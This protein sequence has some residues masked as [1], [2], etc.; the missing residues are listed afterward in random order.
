[1]LAYQ[2]MK[3]PHTFIIVHTYMQNIHYDDNKQCLKLPQVI[4]CLSE[5]DASTHKKKKIQIQIQ[6]LRHINKEIR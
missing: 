3:S 2:L 4:S 5:K 6:I 1:M